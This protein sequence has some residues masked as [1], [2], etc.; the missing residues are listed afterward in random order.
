MSTWKIIA[1]AVIAFA[2]GAAV[3]TTPIQALWWDHLDCQAHYMG[4]ANSD[5]QFRALEYHCN[6]YSR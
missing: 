2:A 4:R 3:P 6:R 5:R 1:I